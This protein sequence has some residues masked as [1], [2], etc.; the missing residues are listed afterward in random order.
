MRLESNLWK[1]YAISALTQTYFVVPVI[2][3]FFQQNGLSMTQIMLLESIFAAA[4]LLLEIPTG[5]VADEFGRKKTIVLASIFGL[6][7][8][9]YYSMSYGFG[10]FA[11]SE[12]LLA[13]GA[14]LMSGADSAMMYDTL[15]GL[16]RE[17]KYKEVEGKM[18]YYDLVANVLAASAT[19]FILVYGL[20]Y[21][22]YASI[23][24]FLCAAVLSFGLVEPKREIQKHPKG[25][26]YRLYKIC[27]FALYKNKEVRLL[28]LY[29]A[30]LSAVGTI[31]FWLYQ[32]YMQQ[33]GV[34]LK[35]FGVVFASF[36]LFAAI[37]SKMAHSIENK[38]GKRWSLVVAG[39][40]LLVGFA[41]LGKFMLIFGAVFILLL[42]LPRGFV[43]PVIKGYIN[44]I[45]WSD[46]RATVLSISSLVSRLIFVAASPIVGKVVD[47][48]G[49]QSGFLILAAVTLVGGG[50]LLLLMKKHQ[51]L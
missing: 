37:S 33:S 30:L 19:G 42:Q 27:R 22:L 46:K 43:F 12:V 48:Y 40:S 45:T 6:A 14:S 5:Y 21:T 44:Q 7:G 16:G 39:A 51:L 32:P 9:S 17:G 41:L 26:A 18:G 47:L 29:S 2:I 13:F 20:R 23:P 36:S 1:M 10:Q 28:I 3:P 49:V 15:K 24:F 25:H 34:A 50:I 4:V 31:G 35:Y 8:I 11:V 38:L